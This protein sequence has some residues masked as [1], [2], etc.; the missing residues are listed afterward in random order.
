MSDGPLSPEIPTVVFDCPVYLQAVLRPDGPAAACL[1]RVEVGAAMLVVSDEIM[2]EV[3][4]VLGRPEFHRPRPRS[5]NPTLVREFLGWL[6]E[7]ASMVH[8][9][10]HVFSYARDPNDEPYLNLAIA[11]RA[12]YI[13]TR[14]RDL[15]DLNVPESEPGKELREHL[16]GIGILDPVA[17]LRRLPHLP[18]GN[19]HQ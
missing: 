8:E 9:V 13:V 1:H 17:F 3:E 6:R 18:T 7:L 14:D 5:L 16:P 10:P 12:A 2:A 4:E 19:P 11:T 15:L